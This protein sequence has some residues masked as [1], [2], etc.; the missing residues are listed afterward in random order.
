MKKLLLLLTLCSTVLSSWSQSAEKTLQK[1]REGLK[2]KKDTIYAKALMN[3]GAHHGNIGNLDSA[4]Y[5][6]KAGIDL[7]IKLKHKFGECAGIMA[8]AHSYSNRAHYDTVP[9]NPWN[10]KAIEQYLA[11]AKMVDEL[12]PG[13]RA[14]VKAVI[15]RGIA[16]VYLNLD[17]RESALPH[18]KSAEKYFIN[19]TDTINILNLYNDLIFC[20]FETDTVTSFRYLKA[21]LAICEAYE[22]NHQGDEYRLE[23]INVQRMHL[24]SHALTKYPEAST[25]KLSLNLLE[26][27]WHRDSSNMDDDYE[28]CLLVTTLAS[29]YRLT[30]Q[31]SKS[32]ELANMALQR[33]DEADLLKTQ[34]YDN[35]AES[36]A[37]TGN[38]QKAY[39]NHVLGSVEYEKDYK[40]ERYTA[41]A[42]LEA[43]YESEK[44]EQQIVV[45]EKDRKAQQKIAAISIGALVIAIGLLLLVLRAKRLQRKLF[46]K[47]KE[48]QKNEMEKRM[49]ELEQTALRAQ[50]N[51][52]FIF[53]SLN[54][55]QRFVINNDAEGV[56]QYLSTFANLIRQTLENSGKPLIPLKDEL[57]YLET[58]LRLEQ[59]R[60]N[61][62][63]KYQINVNPDID[64]EDTYIPNMIIQPYL[65]NSVIHGMAGKKTHEGVI[66]LTIS[67][68]HKLTC[69]VDDNGMGIAASKTIKTTTVDDHESMG[70]AITEKR[71]EMFNTMNNEK[72]ELQVMD[73]S[74]LNTPESGTRIMIKFPL[75]TMAN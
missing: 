47:E 55:V 30:G 58:Y 57:K 72:I 18:L 49:F 21:G 6:I 54:S 37:K 27:I 1:L 70:T 75:H 69:V 24:I 59:M 2:G 31:Y 20:Y 25:N 52:H 51:P 3:I 32:I 62:K 10:Q 48:L 29:L 34:L 8:L 15:D 50:M 43:R 28:T 35:L 23:R 16:A 45:L 9:G 40:R 56:N 7:S 74:E 19:S 4:D 73:K 64:A 41:V 12:R 61:D 11:A 60:S 63:F 33:F 71:I 42:S 66:G 14:K 44:K 65:E 5:Y 26:T 53:N 39:E 67:K 46:A 17:D 36:Y 13:I 68:N 22:K 38:Y